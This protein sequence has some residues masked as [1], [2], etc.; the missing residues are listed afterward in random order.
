MHRWIRPIACL[1][2][3]VAGYAQATPIGY[4]ITITTAYAAGDPFE[5]RIDSAFTELTTGY[6]QV[7][8]TGE[9]TFSGAI[10]TIAVS[11]FA[12]DLSFASDPLVLTPGAAVSVAIPD[13]SNVVGGFN[14]PAYEYRPGIEIT[15]NGTMTNGPLA[16]AVDL[17]V[18]DRDIHSGVPRTDGFGLTTDSFVLQGDDPWGFQNSDAFALGQA[19]GAFTFQQP[20]AEP[21]TASILTAGLTIGAAIRCR[22]AFRSRGA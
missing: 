1:P 7:A 11:A 22:A 4:S 12:G 18:A 3:L 9:T 5:N 8:N 6:F 13:N 20:V 10:G 17:L 14:G 15:L 21:R 19:D 16:E 2:L